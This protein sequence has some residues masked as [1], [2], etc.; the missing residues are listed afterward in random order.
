MRKISDNRTV[1]KGSEDAV[2]GVAGRCG[3]VV[4]DADETNHGQDNQRS[5]PCQD[6]KNDR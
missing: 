3:I 4:T 6:N 2:G 1:D 5:Y